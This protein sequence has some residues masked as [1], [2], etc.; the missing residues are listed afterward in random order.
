MHYNVAGVSIVSMPRLAQNFVR[1]QLAAFFL[2]SLQ[3]V[4]IV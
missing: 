3:E 1:L 4:Y 2:F